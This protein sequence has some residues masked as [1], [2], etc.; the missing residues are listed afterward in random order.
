MKKLSV[1]VP[2]LTWA[3]FGKALRADPSVD[4]AL[5][6]EIERPKFVKWAVGMGGEKVATGEV[7]SEKSTADAIEEAKDK[8]IR[9]WLVKAGLTVMEEQ[10]IARERSP[11]EVLE[12][13]AV[14]VNEDYARD[15]ARDCN[16]GRKVFHADK[17]VATSNPWGVYA[18][19]VKVEL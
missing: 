15:Y 3:S 5:V 4:V 1:T 7:T 14:F 2:H 12:N 9:A 8:A 16:N 18:E 17:G 11:G 19:M 6:V 10:Y 13:E